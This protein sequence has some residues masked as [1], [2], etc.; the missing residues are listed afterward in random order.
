MLVNVD[1]MDGAQTKLVK[2]CH[3]CEGG[4]DTLTFSQSFRGMIHSKI[5][6]LERPSQSHHLQNVSLWHFKHW[7]KV[8]FSHKN[9]KVVVWNTED[10]L[11]LI[12]SSWTNK[13]LFVLQHFVLV[14]SEITAFT[15]ISYL[16]FCLEPFCLHVFVF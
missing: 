13:T 12:A 15:I 4:G 6:S 14:E 10:I 7:G 1:G 16:L 8:L 9:T 5:Y 11:L 2:S 3:R